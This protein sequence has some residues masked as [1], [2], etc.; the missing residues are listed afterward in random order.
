MYLHVCPQ[1]EGLAGR[2]PPGQ[3]LPPPTG[4]ATAAQGTHPTGMHS[5]IKCVHIGV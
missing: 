1:E 4:T 5:C 2:P 3:T